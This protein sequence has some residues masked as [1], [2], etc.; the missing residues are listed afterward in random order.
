MDKNN[1]DWFNL[2]CCLVSVIIYSIFICVILKTLH[3]NQQK[4]DPYLTAT[5]ILLGLS[6]VMFLVNIFVDLNEKPSEPKI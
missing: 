4:L 6:I 5:L 2:A 1:K 3:K